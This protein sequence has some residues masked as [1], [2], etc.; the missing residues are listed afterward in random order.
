MIEARI[1]NSAGIEQFSAWLKHPSGRMPPEG[2]LSDSRLSE[3][4]EGARVDPDRNFA[5]R[6]EFGIALNEW[7]SG[8]S[9]REL[10]SPENDGLWAWLSLIWF[11]QLTA[12]GIRRAE[13]YIVER[14]GSAGSLAYRHAAR[15]SYE[16]VNIHG[17]AAIFCLSSPMPTFGDMTEQLAS[18][19]FIAHNPGFFRAACALYL[20][21]D[22]LKRGASS[23]PK[24]LKKRHKGDRTGFGSVRR[25]AVAL[26]RLNLTYDT[27]LMGAK[28]MCEVLPREFNKWK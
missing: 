22:R 11:E 3:I 19:Q 7:F 9:S 15:T 12:K 8:F 27:E 25:L 16:L 26:R 28:E 10:L 1:L 13:H 24:P 20:D 4:L 5:S 23:K 21:G 6:L 17:E 14:R 2:L 18:R